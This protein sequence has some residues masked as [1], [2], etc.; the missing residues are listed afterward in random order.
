MKKLI[1]YIGIGTL[2]LSFSCKPEL[3]ATTVKLEAEIKPTDSSTKEVKYEKEQILSGVPYSAELMD[4]RITVYLGTEK[5]K[6]FATCAIS[7]YDQKFSAIQAK[8]AIDYILSQN[9]NK[10]EPER[11]QISG[12]FDP[13]ND[14]IFT[15]SKI[16]AEGLEF[17]LNAG[18]Y[19]GNK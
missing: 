12:Y 9:K 11:M 18:K 17:K 14:R 2:L 6:I 7:G 3:P 19:L 16:A 4:D 1:R 10:S 5:K 8:V 13:N 15:C